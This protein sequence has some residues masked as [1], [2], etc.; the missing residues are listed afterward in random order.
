MNFINL[1]HQISPDIL[2]GISAIFFVFIILFSFKFF[3]KDGLLTYIIVSFIACNIQVMKASIFFFSNEPIP[4]GT[5]TYG[6]ISIAIAIVS[7]FFGFKEAKRIIFLG[8]LANIIFNFIIITTLG[9]KP[10]DPSN[11][12][13]ELKF[14]GEN[15]ENMMSIFMIMPSI[16]IASLT[17]YFSSEYITAFLQSFLKKIC[18]SRFLML[19]TYAANTIGAFT[20]LMIMNYLAW[21]F[22]NPSPLGLKQI[23]FSYVLAA[24]PF[25]LFSGLIS[26]PVMF[27]ARLIMKNDDK[28]SQKDS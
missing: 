20:D 26:I 10:I 17:A 1:L 3:K 21:F 22:L 2:T 11:L 6:T 15:H 13:P 18:Q 5:L 28:R 25:R 27:F 19:R 12:E 16:L 8:F 14:L 24:Y 4:L 7:E 9:Y 23:F